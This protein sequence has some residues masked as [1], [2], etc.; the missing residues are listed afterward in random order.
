MNKSLHYLNN[1]SL[2]NEYYSEYH[3]KRIDFT[4]SKL[5]EIGAE[6]IVE[7][8]GHP[9]AMTTEIAKS[10]N[11]NL[12]ATISAEEVSTWPDDIGV[13]KKEYILS[14]KNAYKKQF[15]NYSANIE[16]T[17]FQIDEEPDTV[18]ACEIIEHL[19]RSP[20]IM[21]LNINSWLPL[22]GNLVLTTPNGSQFSNPLH[23]KTQTPAY[24]CNIYE[25]HSYLYTIEDLSELVSLAGFDIIDSGYCEVYNRVGL[26]K[27]YGLLAKI[28]LIYFQNKFQKTIYVIAK[29]N[30]DVNSLDRIPNIYNPST[31]WEFID[32]ST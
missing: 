10:S 9:W 30:R 27:L 23:H 24:R 22:G 11:L 25:R 28:P 1:I 32:N 2:D 5:Y 4:M 31:E 29:K 19:I 14:A 20:H 17:L 13:T 26:A 8:G 7:V 16:R 21:L 15:F 6:D 3:R 12:L 18:I